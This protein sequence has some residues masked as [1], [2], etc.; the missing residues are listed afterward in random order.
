MP[1]FGR[2]REVT[3]SVRR[4]VDR[5][6]P[7]RG[8]VYWGKALIARAVPPT[9][10]FYARYHVVALPIRRRSGTRFRVPSGVNVFVVD[11]ADAVIPEYVAPG[12][13]LRLRS[14]TTFRRRL[15][16]GDLG[17]IAVYRGEFAG[18][19]WIARSSYL[20]E[21]SAGVE[22][23]FRW[24][25]GEGVVWDYNA[26]VAEPYR[27]TPVYGALWQKVL[28]DLEERG[29]KV[30]LGTISAANRYSL[31]V[32]ERLDLQE[33]GTLLFVNIAGLRVCIDGLHGRVRLAR[34]KGLFEIF[35]PVGDLVQPRAPGVS[36][37]RGRR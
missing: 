14:D 22:A 3:G 17:Y 21:E 25:A 6:G 31:G 19:V 11:S 34:R 29:V 26:F 35:V 23:R 37:E 12:V 27:L 1:L 8:L 18:C 20:E 28:E 30:S 7:I 2:I 33:I 5:H 24:A 16:R 36:T 13:A 9:A 32:H 4:T 15:E 10:F